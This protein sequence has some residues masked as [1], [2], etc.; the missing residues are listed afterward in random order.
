MGFYTDRGFD[1]ALL[2]AAY[3]LR[4]SA[5]KY[6]YLRDDMK[7]IPFIEHNNIYYPF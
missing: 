2:T 6:N 5:A 1:D 7:I 4:E 3:S